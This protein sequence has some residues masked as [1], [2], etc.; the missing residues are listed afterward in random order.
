[1]SVKSNRSFITI[2]IFFGNQ[3]NN[4]LKVFTLSTCISGGFWTNFTLHIQH[5]SHVWSV[6]S[7]QLQRGFFYA[8]KLPASGECF[9][10]LAKHEHVDKM[11]TVRLIEFLNNTSS[12]V[13]CKSLSILEK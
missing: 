4:L 12:V 13:E 6:S 3:S 10:G 11:T 5:N 8:L 7:S 1:M 2:I 9:L